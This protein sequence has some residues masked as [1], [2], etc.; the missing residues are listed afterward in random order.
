MPLS[1]QFETKPCFRCSERD[2][3]KGYSYCKPCH[4]AYEKERTKELRKN[5]AWRAKANRSSRKTYVIRRKKFLDQHGS[6][7]QCC[8]ESEYRFLQIDHV[9]DDGA[10]DR[11]KNGKQCERWKGKLQ[12]LCANCN[13][14][15]RYGDC[16][17]QKGGAK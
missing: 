14:A 12:V 1:L 15:K 9:N 6:I 17:H 3:S 2:R 4:A 8:G 10:I 16:P 11:Q 7:C 13:W 5:P